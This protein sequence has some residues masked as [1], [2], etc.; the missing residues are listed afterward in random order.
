MDME[1]NPDKWHIMC[2]IPELYKR[3]TNMVIIANSRRWNIEEEFVNQSIKG[4]SSDIRAS[5]FT[6]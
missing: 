3:D 5:C 1:N 2:K 6:K 4:I